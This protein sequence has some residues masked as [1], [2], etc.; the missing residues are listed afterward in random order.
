[1]ESA[2]SWKDLDNSDI[3]NNPF[4]KTKKGPD[5]EMNCQQNYDKLLRVITTT[6]AWACEPMIYL[7]IDK[8]SQDIDFVNYY[9]DW[10]VN[11]NIFNHFVDCWFDIPDAKTLSQDK[12]IVLI[13]KHYDLLFKPIITREKFLEFTDLNP[14]LARKLSI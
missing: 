13:E 7:F 11:K 9:K 4:T 14:N 3:N 8:L 10:T 6:C 12:L 2:I 5:T 1:M